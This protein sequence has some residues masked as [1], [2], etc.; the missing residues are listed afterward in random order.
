MSYL[1]TAF[2]KKYTDCI[3]KELNIKLGDIILCPYYG[4]DCGGNAKDF[5]TKSLFKI[6]NTKHTDNAMVPLTH[7]SEK[8]PFGKDDIA[9]RSVGAL[10]IIRKFKIPFVKIQNY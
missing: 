4:H 9:Y 5:E 3:L 6:V 7:I 10:Y 1:K 8:T 2:Y